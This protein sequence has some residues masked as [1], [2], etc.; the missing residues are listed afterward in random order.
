MD[1]PYSVRLL[2]K[3]FQVLTKNT[4]R[5]F[6]VRREG[7]VNRR[8]GFVLELVQSSDTNFSTWH[9]PWH[10]S[11]TA[12]NRGQKCVHKCVHKRRDG[13]IGSG[14]GPIWTGNLMYKFVTL[15]S[16]RK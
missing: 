12:P 6:Q 8:L 4:S 1:G 13:R 7:Q 10:L 11:L 2:I 3:V 14:E 5:N 15:N 9:I 16:G